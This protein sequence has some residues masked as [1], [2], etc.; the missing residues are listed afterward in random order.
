MT[1]LDVP[2]SVIATQ[3][4]VGVALG[5]I[6]VLLALGLSLVFGLLGV[7]NFAHGSFY[8]LGA[9][10]AFSLVA[11]TGSFWLSL[12][13]APILTGALGLGVERSLLRRLYA[14][15]GEDSMLLTFGVSLVFI[16]VA[17][18][19]WGNSGV[20]FDAPAML[21]GSVNLGFTQFPAYRLFVIAA[22]AVIVT[23]LWSLLRGTDVGLIVRAGTNDS[24]MVRALG[25]DLGS[26]WS[27]V[28]AAG[29]ALAGIAGVLAAPMRRVY[30][31]M[32]LT[33]IIESFVVVVV[34]GMGSLAGALVAGLLIGIVASVAALFAPKLGEIVIFV[35]MAVVLMVRP[36][37]LFGE[38][39][40]ME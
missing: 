35:V 27:W 2:L 33:I 16:E 11:V 17:R 36:R 24:L 12:L 8:M 4:V 6:Y 21:A 34:G 30:A 13:V 1:L 7:V 25:V 31:E 23:V 40:L 3:I 38:P 28:F 29:C 5:M 39:G 10:L 32:G 26:I 19:I 22:T 9:C 37:G 20:P 15:S 14:R 18:L